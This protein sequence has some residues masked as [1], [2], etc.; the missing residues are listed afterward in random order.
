MIQYDAWSTGERI[1]SLCYVKL[2]FMKFNIKK[3][4]NFVFC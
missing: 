3:G 4:K 1:I 2:A